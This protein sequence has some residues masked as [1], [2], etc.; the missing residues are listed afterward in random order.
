MDGIAMHNIKVLLLNQNYEPLTVVSAQKAIILF[1]LQK[2]EIIE[3]RDRWVR[4]QH[5]TLPMPSI[6]RLLRYIHIPH[7]QVEL[8]RRNILKRD[9]FRCQYCGTT[10]GPFTVDHVIPRTLGGMDSW[11]N[12]VCACVSCNNKKGDRT[13]ERADMKLLKKPRRPSHIF[14]IQNFMGQ[15]EECWKPYIFM[16]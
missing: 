2:A 9:N 15:N 1:Y 10:K 5:L 11:D 8:S 7:K 4:S 6:I 14:F 3:H 12:L 16:N 13:P